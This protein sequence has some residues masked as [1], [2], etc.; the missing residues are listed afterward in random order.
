MNIFLR[1]EFRTEVLMSDG[2]LEDYGITYE[3]LDYKNAET[4]CV[5]WKLLDEVKQ[6]TGRSI[7]LS[8]KML[9]EAVKEGKD[10]VRI[11]FTALS[12]HEED[13]ES[14]KQL[15]KSANAPSAADFTDFE[16]MLLASSLLRNVSES[17]LFE[18]GGSYRLIAYQD[19]KSK[20][21]NLNILS[22]FGEVMEDGRYFLA[23]S[24]EKHRCIIASDAV[25]VLRTA[26]SG[27]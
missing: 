12:P 6:K 3:E 24:S 22:E 4:R 7:G 26:F 18:N 9:I 14:I 16:H 5:L 13:P 27:T 19:A 20:S 21:R 2:E 25:G 1:N 11:C 10:S 8:G 23:E 15:I 17:M